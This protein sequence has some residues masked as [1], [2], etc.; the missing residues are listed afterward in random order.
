MNGRDKGPGGHGGTDYA[1]HVWSHGVHEGADLGTSRIIT[2]LASKG[3][4][5]FSL[6]LTGRICF[7]TMARSLGARCRTPVTNQVRPSNFCFLYSTNS[8]L[9]TD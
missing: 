1:G 6:L 4:R 3:K 5:I 7:M 2:R 9:Y 8:I